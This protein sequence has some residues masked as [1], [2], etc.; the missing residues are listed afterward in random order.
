M[1]AAAA[2]AAKQI[3]GSYCDALAENAQAFC[4]KSAQNDAAERQGTRRPHEVQLAALMYGLAME[5]CSHA[6]PS[7]LPLPG[8][9]SWK[10]FPS[11]YPVALDPRPGARAAAADA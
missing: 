6:A 4:S 8:D 11:I 5:M 10:A 3:L 9:R 1:A 7:P 2:A